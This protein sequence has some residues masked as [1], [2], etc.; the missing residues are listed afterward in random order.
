[1]KQ[2]VQDVKTIVNLRRL[3]NVRRCNNFTTLVGEDV[4]QHSYYTTLLAVLLAKDYNMVAAEHN[5]PLHHYDDSAWSVFDEDEV[6]KKAFYHDIE[7]S[8]FSDIPHNIKHD[9]DELNKEIEEAVQRKFGEALGNTVISKFLS[10][11]NNT[12]KDGSFEG[13]LVDAADM[14]ELAVYCSEEVD[15]GNSSM[16]PLLDKAIRLVKAKKI[17][18]DLSRS[19]LYNELLEYL[20]LSTEERQKMSL[21]DLD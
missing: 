9:S 4:V 3:R 8:Y 5:F 20:S 13:N 7:E 12:A 11:R 6:M 2:S 17:H 15:C 14:L 19:P 18:S 1:M 21:V 16:Q 10:E